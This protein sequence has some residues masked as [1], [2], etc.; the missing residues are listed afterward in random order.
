[1]D[2]ICLMFWDWLCKYSIFVL[3]FFDEM[4]VDVG[5]DITLSPCDA[6]SESA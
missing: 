5:H 2:A 1:M 3:T 4:D 6:T